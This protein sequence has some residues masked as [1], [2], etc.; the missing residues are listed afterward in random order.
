M[1]YLPLAI[2]CTI[3]LGYLIRYYSNMWEES[4]R[5]IIEDDVQHFRRLREME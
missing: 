1:K 4:D 2:F 3:L 5:E